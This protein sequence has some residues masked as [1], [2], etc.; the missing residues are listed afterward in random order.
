[1]PLR[2]RADR[3]LVES[4]ARRVCAEFSLRCEIDDLIGYGWIGL[5]ESRSRFDPDRGVSFA[6]F[7]WLRIRGAILNGVIEMGWLPRRAH[8]AQTANPDAQPLGDV[9]VA[10]TTRETPEPLDETF[11]RVEDV[12]ALRAALQS[13]SERDRA[14]V[15][16]FDLGEQSLEDVGGELG[17]SRSWV[18]RIRQ[19]AIE[20]LRAEMKVAA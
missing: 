9:A 11:A 17:L 14:V 5:L 13:L 18:C 6:S 8:E 12:R 7:A 16:R 10:A 19:G 1:M 2:P 15:E 4:H 3:E 20:H